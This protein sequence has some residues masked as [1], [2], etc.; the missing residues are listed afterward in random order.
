VELCHPLD[1]GRDQ[2]PDFR[3]VWVVSGDALID[4]QGDR[5]PA[6]FLREVSQAARPS[7]AVVQSVVELEKKRVSHVH[8]TGTFDGNHAARRRPNIRGSEIRS[9]PALR[10]QKLHDVDHRACAIARNEIDDLFGVAGLDAGVY[11]MPV[12]RFSTTRST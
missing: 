11:Q 7:D 8:I 3:K 4:Q 12:S 2:R 1:R 5:S 9:P 6:D 10:D